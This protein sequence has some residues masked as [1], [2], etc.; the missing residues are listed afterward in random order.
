MR[1]QSRRVFRSNTV[2]PDVVP[3]WGLLLQQAVSVPGLLL[4]AYRAFHRYS[5]GNQLLALSQCEQRGLQPGPLNTF[6]GW[7]ALGRQVRRG[8]RALTLV[9]PLARKRR[10]D[11]AEELEILTTFAFKSR[12]FLLSQTVGQELPPEPI[13]Y[14]D[15][16]RALAALEIQRVE[17]D[18]FDGNCQGFSRGR[19]I[20]VNPVAS[21]PFK[22]LF[23]EVG[24][25]LLGHTEPEGAA[26]EFTREMQEVEAESVAL[27]C[28]ESLELEGAE[29]CRGYIQKW[30]YKAGKAA[31]PDVCAR[32]IFQA[33]DKILRAG[34]IESETPPIE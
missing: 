25:I 17:F 8:E 1:I 33:T 28:C 2:P 4:R 6:P 29:Y 20:A 15:A 23:H 21:L 5:V 31:I 30:L 9:M 14:F 32:R 22:T 3:H 12:W 24:H 10:S 26:V 34:R 16:D 13:P 18:H 7:M 19:E 27:L 11:G